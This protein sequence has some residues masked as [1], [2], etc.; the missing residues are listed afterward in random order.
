MCDITHIYV[1]EGSHFNNQIVSYY[2]LIL[3]IFEALTKNYQV[4]CHK[5]VLQNPFLFIFDYYMKVAL[6]FKLY[7]F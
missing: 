6:Y 2:H 4:Y 5:L 3:S 1:Q 7:I